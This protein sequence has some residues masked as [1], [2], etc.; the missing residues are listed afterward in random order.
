MQ[1]LKNTFKSPFNLSYLVSVLQFYDHRSC[2]FYMSPCK[3][4]PQDNE[5]DIAQVYIY[6]YTTFQK[7]I[8][9]VKKNFVSTTVFRC[10]AC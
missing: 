7:P 8:Y 10:F 9:K 6:I 3:G 4:F 5:N 1:T 2:F